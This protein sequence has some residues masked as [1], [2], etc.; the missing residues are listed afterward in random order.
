MRQIADHLLDPSG[1]PGI[2][3]D[4]YQ[5][6]EWGRNDEASHR[7]L[8]RPTSGQLRS[9]NDLHGRE[10]ILEEQDCDCIRAAQ[11]AIRSLLIA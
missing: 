6:Q 10:W 1:N 4:C 2:F 8:C 7:F 3:P 11:S 5:I 9:Q